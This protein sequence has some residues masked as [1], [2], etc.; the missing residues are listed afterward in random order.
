MAKVVRIRR[1]NGEIVVGCDVYIGRECNMGGW[2]LR[3]SI[4]HN[5]FSVKEYGRDKVLE[6]Y[7]NYIRRDKYL[8]ARLY[9]L[10]GKTLGCWCKPEKCHGDILIKL[11]NE[12]KN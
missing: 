11:I 12:L 3:K 8:M 2:K 6:K 10:K 5:P 9:R 1:K 7:E 4:W